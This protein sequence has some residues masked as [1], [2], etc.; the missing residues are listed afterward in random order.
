MAGEE[1]KIE[2]TEAGAVAGGPGRDWSREYKPV[3]ATW[4]L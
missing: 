3:R 4:P 2:Q 1:A